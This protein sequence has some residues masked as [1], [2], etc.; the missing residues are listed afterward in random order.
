MKTKVHADMMKKDPEIAEQEG[1]WGDLIDMTKKIKM[2]KQMKMRSE[3]DD[4]EEE[5]YW[6]AKIHLKLMSLKMKITKCLMMIYQKGVYRE[7]TET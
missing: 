2:T 3:E 1:P 6:E 7:T 4:Q 5:W